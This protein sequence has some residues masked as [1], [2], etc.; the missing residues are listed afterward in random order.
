MRT[1]HEPEGGVLDGGGE[2]ESGT[3]A[4]D[5]ARARSGALRTATISD[6]RWRNTA[7]MAAAT[8]RTFKARI[9]GGD[10]VVCDVVCDVEEG[11]ER[12]IAMFP[13]PNMDFSTIYLIRYR[14]PRP[15]VFR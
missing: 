6:A 8:K 5:A 15:F 14:P 1:R 9:C 12:R 3:D 10:D 7:R 13:R 4:P 2:E 11:G